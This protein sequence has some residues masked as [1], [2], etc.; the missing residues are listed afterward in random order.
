MPANLNRS[1]RSVGRRLY[2]ALRLAALAGAIL[3]GIA[4]TGYGVYQ[5]RVGLAPGAVDC[6]YRTNLL[7]DRIVAALEQPP[8]DAHGAD[9]QILATLLRE[10][11]AACTSAGTPPEVRSQLERL[12]SLHEEAAATRS[13]LDAIRQELFAHE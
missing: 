12:A 2:L 5:Q 13:R 3:W 9:T 1:T 8:D 6:P 11:L 7:R 10:T 4:S